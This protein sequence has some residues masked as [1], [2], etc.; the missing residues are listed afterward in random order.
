MKQVNTVFI[1][2]EHNLLVLIC[3]LKHLI[4][5]AIIVKNKVLLKSLKEIPIWTVMNLVAIR[6]GAI[7][8]V[9]LNAIANFGELFT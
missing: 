2:T 3:E 9:A 6:S 5:L 1:S 7:Y 8:V 4:G